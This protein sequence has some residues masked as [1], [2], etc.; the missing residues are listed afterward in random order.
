MAGSNHR[1]RTASA[2]ASVE[3]GSKVRPA[4]PTNSGNDVAFA[5]INGLQPETSYYFRVRAVSAA[6]VR[7]SNP[8][9]FIMSPA[10]R[11][12]TGAGSTTHREGFS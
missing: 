11:A 1:R 3:R 10:A 7:T 12:V 4:S 9:N 8:V 2:R 6:G 5:P